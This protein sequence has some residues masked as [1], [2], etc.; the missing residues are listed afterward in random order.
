ME[1]VHRQL[2]V[3]MFTDVEGYTAL[4]GIDQDKALQ[5][6]EMNRDIQKPLISEC[7]GIFIKEI[8]DGLLATFSTAYDAVNCA[9]KIQQKLQDNKA[10]KLKIGLHL[11]EIVQLNE[12]VF[13]DGVNIASRLQDITPP[14]GIYISQ[15]VYDQIRNVSEINTCY[16]G[17][18][19]FKNSDIRFKIYAICVEGLLDPSKAYFQAKKE[20]I[21][22]RQS[23]IKWIT[24]SLILLLIVILYS[25]DLFTTKSSS[26]DPAT[27]EK[28]LAVL[29]FDNIGGDDTNEYFSLGI[30]EDII[31]QL[32]KIKDL[33]VIDR[34]YLRKY[35]HSNKTYKE[36]GE[37]LNVNNLLLGSIRKIEDKIR[38][39][40][41]LI[42][43]ETEEEKW[44]EVYDKPYEDIFLIQTEVAV[45][46]AN[47]LK[48]RITPEEAAEI[49]EKPTNN[50]TAYDLYLKGREYY[51]R[52]TIPDNLSAIEL[53]YDVLALDSQ[54]FEAHAGLSDAFSQM[55]QK[56]NIKNFYLDSAY[57]H[58]VIAKN[59]YPGK[60]TGYKAMGLYYSIIGNSQKAIVEYERA[61][62]IDGNI[63]AVINLSRIYYRTGKLIQAIALLKQYQWKNPV[64]ANLWFNLGATYFR[65][66]DYQQAMQYLGKA[67]SIDPN[68]VNSLLLK[69]LISI[70]LNEVETTFS[71]SG[72]LGIIGNDNTE[73]IL[74]HVGQVIRGVAIN[75]DDA[76]SLSKLIEG[77]E[78]DFIDLPHLYNLFGYIYYTGGLKSKADSL[79]EYR[80][81]YNFDKIENGEMS[82]KYPYEI[83]QIYA[84]IGREENAYQWLEKS[85][86]AGWLEY[87]YGMIDPFFQR[88]RY[89]DKFQLLIQEAKFKVDSVQMI[90]D[91]SII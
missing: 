76:N 58:A 35:Q 49:D 12:D 84:L 40:A 18:I 79:F 37:E 57:H 20:E 14:Q 64:N 54:F 77:R 91:S 29:A 63:E 27:E 10:L 46:I 26:N 23:K 2:S 44:G 66:N 86:E 6:L 31:I 28:T 48:A 5:L 13:G 34:T 22:H 7:G 17:E 1:E 80:M 50:I 61:V 81:H 55:A 25:F 16:L 62:E 9:I 52:Y 15:S 19:K 11:G 36:I 65:L 89:Q 47:A 43:V 73:S 24:A 39:Y 21:T 53:F 74:L 32:S 82:Y 88:I 78:I 56:S 3:I 4:M 90:I 45:S 68:Q 70:S 83:S 33:K 60:S 51:L 67:L 71:V 30:T 38:I 59:K 72:R 69:W 41:R 75:I 85:V 87:P 8:G 42:N